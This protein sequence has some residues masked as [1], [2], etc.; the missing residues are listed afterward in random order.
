MSAGGAA[1]MPDHYR[2]ALQR[3]HDF[4]GFAAFRACPPD[5]MP[6][7]MPS[8][9]VGRPAHLW[10]P[11]SYDDAIWMDKSVTE[12]PNLTLYRRLAWPDQPTSAS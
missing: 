6:P 8:W 12:Y 7:E 2:C 10:A 4:G 9:A 1:V 11:S 3:R 5:L